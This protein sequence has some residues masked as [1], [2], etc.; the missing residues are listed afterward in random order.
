[1]HILKD[2]I[3]FCVLCVVRWVPTE[4][5]ERISWSW[6]YWWIWDP[7]TL[8]NGWEPNSDFSGKVA[9]DLNHWPIFSSNPKFSCQFL[10]LLIILKEIIIHY[11]LNIVIPYL[12]YINIHYL[13]VVC[14]HIHMYIHIHKCQKTT[15]KNHFSPM[16]VLEIKFRC[17]GL[18]ASA[19]LK[20]LI[21]FIF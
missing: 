9:S 6:S 5:R 8:D 14:T 10:F 12:G 11:L 3:Y 15:W 20:I 17:S 19:N 18:E 2:F 21:T 1:M 13:F 7:L 16:W 4:A